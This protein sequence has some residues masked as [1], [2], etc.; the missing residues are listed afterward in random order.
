ME[1]MHAGVCS[2][3]GSTSSMAKVARWTLIYYAATTLA[4]VVLGIIL[5]NVLNPGRGSPL[6]GDGVSDCAVDQVQ[7]CVGLEALRISQEKCS[8]AFCLVL[9]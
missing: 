8:F 2:L 9:S 5:V 7:H 6:N 4:A 1:R 3:R